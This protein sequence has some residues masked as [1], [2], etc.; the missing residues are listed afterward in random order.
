MNRFYST[1]RIVSM[2]ELTNTTQ[3]EGEVVVEYINRWRALSLECKDRLSETS[4]VGMCINGM[5]WDL[6][7]I[8]NGIKPKSFHKL[9]TRAHDMEITVNA[10]NKT[11]SSSSKAISEK[12]EFKKTEKGSKGSSKVAMPVTTS[13]TPVKISVKPK[14]E[15]EKVAY[16][17]DFKGD[18]PTLKD[19]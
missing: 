12:K 10:R 5:N 11:K 19:L 17:K 13:N 14:Y 6:L 9:A 18:K 1:R 8:L 16:T 2:S 4:A 15:M 7:Y 3:W